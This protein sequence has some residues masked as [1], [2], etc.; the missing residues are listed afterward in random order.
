[1]KKES[2]DL[3]ANGVREM[4][5]SVIELSRSCAILWVFWDKENNKLYS[6][7]IRDHP[8]FFGGIA[9]SLFLGFCVITYRLFQDSKDVLS[10]PCFINSLPSTNQIVKDALIL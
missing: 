2:I 6:Q 4:N 10:L 8:D 5:G 7:V 9:D 3:F 1:V